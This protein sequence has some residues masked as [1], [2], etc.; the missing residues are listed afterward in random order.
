VRDGKL[1]ID[2]NRNTSAHSQGHISKLGTWLKESMKLGICESNLKRSGEDG[3]FWNSRCNKAGM[4]VE[5]SKDLG[6]SVAR[7]LIL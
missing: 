1:M 3:P 4:P 6:V 2:P 7:S 5:V